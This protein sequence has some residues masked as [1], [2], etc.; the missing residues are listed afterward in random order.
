MVVVFFHNF[1]VL[2]LTHLNLFIYHM[3]TL[4]AVMADYSL[5][6]VLTVGQ[7]WWSIRS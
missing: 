6:I 3:L 7:Q 1:A 5:L 4:C 2:Y